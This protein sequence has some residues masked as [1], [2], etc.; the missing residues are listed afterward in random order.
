MAA[1]GPTC[2]SASIDAPLPSL[3]APSQCS[4]ARRWPLL[5]TGKNS[6]SPWHIPSSAAFQISTPLPLVARSDDLQLLENDVAHLLERERLAQERV[7]AARLQRRR[8]GLAEIPR[9]DDDA[10]VGQLGIG[11]HAGRDFGAGD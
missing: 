4:S 10:R 11:A 7:D 5:E 6:V 2:S 9:E 8:L 3:R 1:S